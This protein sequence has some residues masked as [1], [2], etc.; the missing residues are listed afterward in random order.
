M[1]ESVDTDL[2]TI[3]QKAIEEIASFA[4]NDGIKAEKEPIAFGLNSL[5]LMFVM[6]E[7]KGS[8]EELEKIIA[9]IDQVESVECIDVRRAVG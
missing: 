2:E 9:Q 5:K 7:S 3:K 4:G 8:T 1:P 6:D